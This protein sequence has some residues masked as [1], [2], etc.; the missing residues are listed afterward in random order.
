M[1]F[2]YTPY[3]IPLFL[4]A[5][6]GVALSWYSFRRPRPP[7]ANTFGLM[8]IA[9]AWWSLCYALTV[10]AIDKP[11]QYLFNRLKYVG[12]L[13][14][15]PLWLILSLRYTRKRSHFSWRFLI[16]IFLPAILLLPIVLTNH[17]TDLWWSDVWQ[18]EFNGRSVLMNSHGELYYLHVAIGYL[19]YS[20]YL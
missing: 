5:A 13:A 20:V 7:E 10:L 17:L 14:V 9:L 19:Y 8:T 11:T 15:P 6:M 18:E 16:L 12:V 1:S 3:A 2:E 4:A